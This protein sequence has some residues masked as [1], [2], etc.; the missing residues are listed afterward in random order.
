MGI[1]HPAG[2]LRLELRRGGRF[3]LTLAVWD[4]VVGAVAGRRELAGRWRAEGDA[5][6][7]RAPAR[8][9]HY[10][11]DASGDLV[12]QRSSLPTF[13]DGIDLQPRDRAL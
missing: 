12:W 9:I 8:E 10:R 7:L 6:E 5:L 13:A 11:V 2:E 4:P 1:E 3:C